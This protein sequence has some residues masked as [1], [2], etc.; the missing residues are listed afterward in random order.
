MSQE[1]VELVREATDAVNRRDL[2]AFVAL[3]SPDVAWESRSSS[4]FPGFRDVYR[5]PAEVREWVALASELIEDFHTE[6]E[7]ITDLGDDRLLIA[8]V[9]TGRGK[10]SGLP[11]ELRDWW[12]LWFAEGLITRRQ[13]FWSR[14]EALEAARPSE[15]P[16][17]TKSGSPRPMP[18]GVPPRLF[19]GGS[20]KRIGPRIGSR[21][22]PTDDGDNVL[23]RMESNVFVR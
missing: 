4:P 17:W 11:A 21:L 3:L 22:P 23:L 8:Y 19:A 10:G 6:V 14:D 18:P 16:P 20:E 1:N 12:V 2:D 13:A 5:G 9:R 7:E 15:W